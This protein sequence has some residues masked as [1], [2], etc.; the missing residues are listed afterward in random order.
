MSYREP[1]PPIGPATREPTPPTMIDADVVEAR[2]RS[3][4]AKV[5][6]LLAAASMSKRC[7]ECAGLGCIGAVECAA[8][9]GTGR[10]P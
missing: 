6:A 5:D 10:A 3:I 7:L 1:L 2:L 8:C 4:E 9:G